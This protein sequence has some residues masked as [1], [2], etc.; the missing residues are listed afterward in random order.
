[1]IESRYGFYFEAAG[2][3]AA[4][5]AIA[6]AEQFFEGSLAEESLGRETGQNSLDVP[7]GD[8]PVVMVFELASMPTDCVPG[9]EGLR[10]HI[11]QVARQ[12]EGSNGHDRMRLAW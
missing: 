1:M 7:A 4:Q 5:G 6:P 12:T 11:E 3:A 2:R 9:I 8:D 10:P